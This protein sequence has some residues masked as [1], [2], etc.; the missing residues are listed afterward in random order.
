MILGIIFLL[1]SLERTPQFSVFLAFLLVIIGVFFAVWAL[2]LNKRASYLF[3]ASLF[4]MAGIFLFLSAME[5]ITLQI[6][7][8][9]PLLSVFSGLALLPVGW[10]R[11][12]GFS[13]RYF[14]SSCAFVTLGC[15][16]LIFSLHIVPFSFSRF[17]RDW[18][19]LI[20]ILGGIT[21]ALISLSAKNEQSPTPHN[22]SACNAPAGDMSASEKNCEIN[23]GEI[24]TV[25]KEDKKDIREPK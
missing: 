15:V 12:G 19:Y 9:W 22:V 4:L 6:S 10:R 24:K 14:V 17:I 20:F 13:P 18:W 11:Q 21:L 25:N 16:L 8:A 2:T 7:K 23:A 1:G 5:I 3:L